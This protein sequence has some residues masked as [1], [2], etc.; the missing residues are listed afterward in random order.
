MECSICIEPIIIK[1]STQEKD[2][3]YDTVGE[4][5][6]CHHKFHSDCI[7]KWHSF[8]TD[9]KCPICRTVSL[10][11]SLIYNYKMWYEKRVDIDLN[12][13]FLVGNIIE[14]DNMM[15][16]TRETEPDALVAHV[17]MTEDITNESPV[18][19]RMF[20]TILNIDDMN[21]DDSEKDVEEEEG[22]LDS[23]R[24][25]H[26]TLLCRICGD[27]TVENNGD[28]DHRCYNCNAR[29]HESCLHSTASEIGESDTWQQ[30]IE[31]RSLTQRIKGNRRFRIVNNTNTDEL[32][33]I[34]STK[35]KIQEHVRK[36]LKQYYG[37]GSSVH[38]TG[39]QFTKIN[40]T[41]SRSLY[42]MSR[43]E[44]QT[45]IDYDYQAKQKVLHELHK[46]G[47]TSV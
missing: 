33:K 36:I 6:P 40:Q 21:D 34:R 13:G 14:Y 43:N 7:R 29:Y 31:C 25:E 35:R 37:T 5:L 44:Y 41:V 4:L 18:L 17:V 12:K 1:S 32:D 23:L 11:M 8:A 10:S 24:E 26:N 28:A 3:I 2:Q 45:K 38:L 19:S 22:I 9:L 16:S 30:C 20:Q 46:L 42:S 47:Y 27:D 39:E 15:T